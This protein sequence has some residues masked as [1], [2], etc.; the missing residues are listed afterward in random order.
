MTR[1]ISTTEKTVTVERQVSN[2]EQPIVVGV[3]HGGNDHSV[4]VIGRVL[5]DGSIKII[6]WVKRDI[7]ETGR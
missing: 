7:T 2:D 6:E 3:D 5:P 1:I 4:E